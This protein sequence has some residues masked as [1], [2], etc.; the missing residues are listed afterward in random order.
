M[1]SPATS[2]EVS[3]QLYQHSHVL[4]LELKLWCFRLHTTSLVTNY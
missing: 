4:A 2:C 3:N 1:S